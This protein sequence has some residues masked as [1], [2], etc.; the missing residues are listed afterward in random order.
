M[1]APLLQVQWCR[2]YLTFHWPGAYHASMATLHELGRAVH[3]RRAEMGLTQACL[4]KL[5]GLT[6]QTINQVENGTVTDLSLNRAE[7]LARTIGLSLSVESTSVKAKPGRGSM[8]ALVRA[9]RLASVSYRQPL[10][11]S[12]LRKI[13]MGAELPCDYAPHLHV[14]LDEAPPSLLASVAA[15]LEREAGVGR[16]TTWKRF[17]LLARDLKS[18]RDIWQ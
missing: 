15:Q 5:S 4:A 10:E 11:P 12:R 2:I 17:R 18:R 13:I 16:E 8:S 3:A 14:F 9:A 6:R 7:R 1:L